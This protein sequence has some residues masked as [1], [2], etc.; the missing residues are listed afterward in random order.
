MTEQAAAV[1]GAQ[2]RRQ[3]RPAVGR[4]A[5]H[6]IERVAL[7]RL[8]QTVTDVHHLREASPRSPAEI[9]ER[10]VQEHLRHPGGERVYLEAAQPPHDVS[11][12]RRRAEVLQ[13]FRHALRDR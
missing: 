2:F 13:T 12:R 5:D 1:L 11:Q 6:E 8:F 10:D 4:I 9:V 3:R 7:R